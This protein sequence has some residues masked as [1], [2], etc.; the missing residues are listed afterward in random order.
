MVSESLKKN[1]FH[2]LLWSSL[3]RFSVQGIQFL[4]MIIIARVLSPKD[5][6]LVGMLAIFL[7]I[8]Q[9]LIDGG[10]SQAL[11]RKQDRTEMDNCTVFYFNIIVGFLLYAILFFIAP[12]VADFYNENQLK[13]LLRAMG[14]IVIFNSLTVVQRAIFTIELD[15][16]T[17]AKASLTSAILTGGIGIYLVYHGF[18]VWTLAIQQILSSLLNTILLWYY[19][20][21]RP[22]FLYSWKSFNVLF[23]FGSKLLGVS[24]IDTTFNNIYSLVIGKVFSATTLGYY[25]RATNFSEMPSSNVTGILQRVT[26]PVL[27][28]FQ[29]DDVKLADAYRKFLRLAAYIVFPLMCLLAAVSRP[30]INLVLGAKWDYCYVLLI[31]IC[32]N[33]MWYPIHAINL[34]LLQVKGRSDLFLKLEII[35]KIILIVSILISIHFGVLFMCYMQILTCFISLYLNC[36][37]SGAFINVGFIK[38]MKDL[39]GILLLSLSMFVIIFFTGYLFLNNYIWL[40]GGMIFSVVYYLVISKIANF[41]ELNYIIKLLK[42][43]R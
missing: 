20:T 27:C 39:L 37:Y 28:K 24:I 30:F 42:Y 33:M 31:P 23:S 40:F 16:K 26:Y 5:Y 18:G 22:K 17:Q 6:G 1:T 9:S 34:N 2:G 7:A 13:V 12:Y 15:F 11:I 29:D 41:P 36:Y 38:Q 10:F 14:V 25:S 21:W 32:F 8:S 4:V 35:K 3:E 43:D 19:S